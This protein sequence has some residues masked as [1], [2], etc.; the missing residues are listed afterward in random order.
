MIFNNPFAT[1]GDWYK[2]NV[3]LHSCNSDGILTPEATANNYQKA[4]Y[5]FIVLTDHFKKTDSAGLSNNR[6]L[7]ISGEET[8]PVGCSALGCDFE[9]LALGI[10]TEIT[11]PSIKNPTIQPQVA[12]DRIKQAGGVSVLAHP[13][14]SCLTPEEIFPLQGLLGIEIFNPVFGLG[15]RSYSVAHWDILLSMGCRLYGFAGDDSHGEFM[16]NPGFIM[17]KAE[18]LT[19]SAIMNSIKKGLYYASNGPLLYDI[20]VNDTYVSAKTSPVKFINFVGDASFMRGSF[21]A[22]GKNG[23]IDNATYNLKKHASLSV[24]E[25]YLRIECTDS[26]GQNAWSNPMFFS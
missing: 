26:I 15:G 24:K 5:D 21:C 13:C 3:H 17:V 25:K 12:I 19:E 18:Q 6:F 8:N 23:F 2:G 10:R 20:T 9:F 16:P 22:E 11:F 1:E 7:V 14:F 4:G